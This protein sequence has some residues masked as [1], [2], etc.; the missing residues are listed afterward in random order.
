MEQARR[1]MKRM[2]PAYEQYGINALTGFYW[3]QML[4]NW[5]ATG[6][7]E[8]DIAIEEVNPMNSHGLYE[9]FLGVDDRFTK[10]KSNVLFREIIRKMW[11]ELLDFP[12]NPAYTN[13]EKLSHLLVRTGL[14][15]PFKEFKYLLNH[16]RY[17]IAC[18]LCRRGSR[19]DC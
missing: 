9:V 3:E 19:L 18:G 7:S 15:E 11:P 12:I 17:L 13:R 4:G 16:A 2:I 6:N 14:F 5:G 1:I 8:S 10:Y